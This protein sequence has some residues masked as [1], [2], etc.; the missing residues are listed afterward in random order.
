MLSDRGLHVSRQSGGDFRTLPCSRSPPNV[1]RPW[2]ASRPDRGKPVQEFEAP[3][4]LKGR[5]I[6]LGATTV[7][8]GR[9][10]RFGSSRQLSQSP[11]PDRATPSHRSCTAGSSLRR[12]R[13]TNKGVVN[14]FVMPLRSTMHPNRRENVY[15]GAR[16]T[17]QSKNICHSATFFTDMLAEC[18]K[19]IIALIWEANPYVGRSR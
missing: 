6:P 1:A 9:L 17:K 13:S 10:Q 18:L 16:L 3:L 8:Q 5:R 2:T 4:N 15:V 7:S 19:L 11:V 14:I 12:Q